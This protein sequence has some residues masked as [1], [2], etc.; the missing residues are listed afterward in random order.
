M[1]RPLALC[2]AALCLTVTLMSGLLCAENEGQAD[3][4]KATQLK[5]SANTLAD[6]TEVIRLSESAMKQGLDKANTKFAQNLLS[7]ALVQR[8]S[9]ITGAIFDAKGPDPKWPQFRK[10]ALA[11]L[12]KAIEINSKTAARCCRSPS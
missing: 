2:F 5:M 3:L 11:D 8:G 9:A 6:L 1:T 4:D 10:L 12:E 7:S